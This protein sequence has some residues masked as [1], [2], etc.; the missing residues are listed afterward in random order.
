MV[1][2]IAGQKGTGKSLYTISLLYKLRKKYNY[3][4]SN[5]PVKFANR[6][7]SLNWVSFR[8]PQGAAIL[9]DESQ[10]YFNSREF[11]KLTKNGTGNN[12]LDFLTMC[13]HYEVDIYFITQSVN[14]IDLQIR[15]LSD[16]VIYLKRTIKIPFINKPFLVMGYKFPDIMEFEKFVNPNNFSNDY[17]MRL[18]FKFIFKNNLKQYDTHYIDKAYYK[19]EAIPL[20]KW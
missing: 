3:I 19:K 17:K 6:I 13:R 5:F 8:F 10:L 16:L 14:R 18:L 12:L 20:L 4:F 1:Y 9:I 2:L 15:E 11:S 7:D